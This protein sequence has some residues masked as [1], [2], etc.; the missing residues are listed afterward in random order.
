[1]PNFAET[2][3]ISAERGDRACDVAALPLLRALAKSCILYDKKWSNRLRFSRCPARRLLVHL[4][5]RSYHLRPPPI[6][7]KGHI[8]VRLRWLHSWPDEW[9]RR[10]DVRIRKGQ[11]T[12]DHLGMTTTQGHHVVLSLFSCPRSWLGSENILERRRNEFGRDG[13]LSVCTHGLMKG[14]RGPFLEMIHVELGIRP[15]TRHFHFQS[16]PFL[17][18]AHFLPGPRLLPHNFQRASCRPSA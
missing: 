5:F 16:R 14:R 2:P 1:M 15:L 7:C 9:G 3:N 17:L 18:T 8:R 6:S 12:M 11:T 13:Y 10:P 4:I